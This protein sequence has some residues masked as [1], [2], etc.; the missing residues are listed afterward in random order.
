MKNVRFFPLCQHVNKQLCSCIIITAL[1]IVSSPLQANTFLLE[2][3]R[4]TEV[5]NSVTQQKVKVTGRVVDSTGEPLP[6]A[7]VVIQGTPQ[8]VTTDMDGNFSMEVD[9][10]AKLEISYLGMELSLIHI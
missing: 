1:T 5:L 4:E 3:V 8:G 9:L 2:S 10:N 7:A 6:G